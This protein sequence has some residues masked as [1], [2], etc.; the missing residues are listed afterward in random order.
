MTGVGH[1][2]RKSSHRW[3][4]VKQLF[5]L[6]L[7]CSLIRVAPL[8]GDAEPAPTLDEQVLAIF[9]DRCVMCHGPQVARPKGKF[10]YITDLRRVAANPEYIVPFQPAQSLLYELVLDDEMPEAD[11]D[12][13]PLTAQ[14]KQ[15]IHQWIESGAVATLTGDGADDKPSSPQTREPAVVTPADEQ[16][17][18]K[19]P[20]PGKLQRVALWVGR[21][22]PASVH[23]PL[24]LLV[25]A[26][27]AELLTMLPLRVD[28]RSTARFCLAVGALGAVTAALLGWLNAVGPMHAQRHSWELFLHR[29]LGTATASGTIVALFLSEWHARSQGPKV[30][31]AYR[32]ALF[33][34][35][36]LVNVVGFLG[37]VNVYGLDHYR[38]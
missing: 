13:P 10:G 38:L 2:C 11:S 37:G 4:L 22:H 29:W 28:L 7:V 18:G 31:L 15:V 23:L 17:H 1:R 24:G 33:A 21:F 34:V 6:A 3:V 8:L 14:Q 27:L 30:R 19:R 25:A 32:I 35:A 5:G 12:V 26:A 9:E 20:P 16:T 36:G